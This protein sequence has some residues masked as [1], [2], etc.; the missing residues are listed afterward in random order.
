[1]SDTGDGL[2][3]LISLV[4]LLFVGIFCVVWL[5]I[6]KRWNPPNKV[7][8]NN[9][10]AETVAANKVSTGKLNN[11]NGVPR[12]IL[13]IVFIGGGLSGNLVLRGT[14]SSEALVFVGIGL[15]GWGITTM[16]RIPE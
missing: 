10:S 2:N 9:V 3:G 15:V 5:K 7:S 14:D 16:S 11:A 6:R 12:I 4:V 8:A 13:G 1:M